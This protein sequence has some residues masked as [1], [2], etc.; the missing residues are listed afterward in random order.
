LKDFKKIFKTIILVFADIVA[1]AFAYLFALFLRVDSLPTYFD[2]NPQ[3]AKGVMIALPFIVA[4]FL[5]IL[6]VM[7]MY[8]IIWH[9]AGLNEIGRVIVACFCSSFFVY[10]VLF[11]ITNINIEY[12]G[13]IAVFPRSVYL[14][15]PFFAAAFIIAGRFA[16]RYIL[17]INHR[18]KKNTKSK[19]NGNIMIIGAGDGACLFLNNIHESAYYSGATPVCLIDDDKNKHGM[20]INNV[21][22]MGTRSDII[23][24]AKE[25]NIDMIIF[26]I[27]SCPSE[28]KS[29]I[30][31]ICQKTGCILKTLPAVYQIEKEEGISAKSVRDVEIE[32]LLGRER[33]KIQTVLP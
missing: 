11:L 30:L 15:A 8:R 18:K 3:S 6:V 21:P 14:S 19:V 1:V 22:V 31:K 2:E 32:D 13:I 16:M 4:V 20:L 12:S 10:A 7:K 24:L 28:E 9:Y 23:R 27:P 26:A 33:R 29:K 5:T 25:K 17:R